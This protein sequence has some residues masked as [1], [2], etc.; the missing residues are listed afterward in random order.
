MSMMQKVYKVVRQYLNKEQARYFA[1]R[2]TEIQLKN[3]KEIKE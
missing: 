3:K 2:F 1:I